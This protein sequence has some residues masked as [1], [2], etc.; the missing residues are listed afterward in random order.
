MS[1][2]ADTNYKYTQL[3]DILVEKITSGEWKPHDRIPPEHELCRRYNLSRITVRDALDL[4]AKD[5]YIYKKQGKGTFVAVRQIEQKLTKFYSLREAIEAKGMVPSNKVLS[6]KKIPA[7]GKVKE[8]LLLEDSALIYELIR[9]LYA[10]DTPYAVE[11]SYI[12]V[13]IYPELT[14]DLIQEKGLYKS[15]QFFNIIPER[16][17]ETLKAIPISR[18]DALLLGVRSSDTAINIERITYSQNYI[19]EYTNAIIKS[20]FFSYTVELN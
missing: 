14:L 8:A 5:G 2:K 17:R 7:V 1:K 4:L 16:A 15:M 13:S 11:T 9:C 18:E 10:E 12:P 20:D 19:I 6:F 3:Y